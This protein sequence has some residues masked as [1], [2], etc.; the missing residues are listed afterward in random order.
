MKKSFLILAVL[1]AGAP[2]WA[3]ENVN[4]SIV[5]TGQDH[6]Y[7]NQGP[8]KPPNPDDPYFGQDAQ[9]QGNQPS[10]KDNGDGTVTDLVTGLVWVKARGPKMGWQEAA[11]GA[12]ACTVG[13]FKDWRMPSIKELYSL[14][15]FNGRCGRTAQDSKPYLDSKVFDFAYGEGGEEMGQRLIDCQD[16]SATTYV[17]TTMGDNPT[18]FGVNFADG[19][20]KGYGKTVHGEVQDRDK[21]YVRYVRGNP[22]YGVNHF[23]DNKD[24]T[25]SDRATGL[26]WAQNDS[27]KGMNWKE[28]LAWVR[29][30]NEESYLGYNDWRLPNAKELQS[31]VDYTRSPDSTHSAAIDPLFHCMEIKN[32]GGEVDYPYYWTSTTHL[33]NG[34]AVYI[35]FGRALGYMRTSPVLDSL[36]L[37][38]VHGA[39]AQ[40]SDPKS[41]YPDDH[42]KGLGPQGDVVRIFNYVRCVRGGEDK[43]VQAKGSDNA[44]SPAGPGMEAQH[45]G[46][47][48]VKTPSEKPRP[49]NNGRP[50]Q[51]A[52]DACKG[53]EEGDKVHFTT[54]QGDLLDCH[55]RQTLDGLAAVPDERL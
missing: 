5:D 37:M 52:I 6:C 40:R 7:G 22:K 21:R 49:R 1:L 32:E 19:R 14:I 27:G 31:L 47:E 30:M 3:K 9:H 28:A 55:C 29:R 46:M 43:L 25:V 48:K 4:Y 20:I 38:D 35:A 13:G 33:D 26:I 44:Y 24:G 18:A 17:S 39:G 23:Q 36:Q 45:D 42:A 50:P 2:L 53:H 51:E 11:D 41:G 34:G 54:P 16:W 15:H 12:A 8:I 10:Y